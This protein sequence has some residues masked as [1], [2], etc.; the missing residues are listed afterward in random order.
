MW[1]Y[2]AWLQAVR[3]RATQ[4]IIFYL[5]SGSYC[6]T[7]QLME[8]GIWHNC[9]LLLCIILLIFLPF[10][11]FLLSGERDLQW[12]GVYRGLNCV[13][14]SR[15]DLPSWNWFLSLPSLFPLLQMFLSQKWLYRSTLDLHLCCFATQNAWCLYF[16]DRATPHL[17]ISA[18]SESAELFYK[19]SVGL[20]H[21]LKSAGW[22]ASAA[23]LQMTVILQ[24]KKSKDMRLQSQS[25]VSLLDSAFLSAASSDRIH[26]FSV[27]SFIMRGWDMLTKR[28]RDKLVGLVNMQQPWKHHFYLSGLYSVPVRYHLPLRVSPASRSGPDWKLNLSAITTIITVFLFN[29]HNHHSYHTKLALRERERLNIS[30]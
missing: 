5:I 8:L 6:G 11:L 22:F 26:F 29:S 13:I 23:K 27:L 24:Q 12:R 18:V 1:K 2:D 16:G 15:V 3:F 17:S 19:L 30:W 9:Y 20:H 14:S 10:L 25:F 21:Q 7:E 28:P 4:N